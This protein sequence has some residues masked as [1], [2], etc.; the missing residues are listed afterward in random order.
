MQG[1]NFDHCPALVGVV[2]NKF[3][4]ATDFHN[5]RDDKDLHDVIK[6]T[7]FVRI[8]PKAYAGKKLRPLSPILHGNH[9]GMETFVERG[10]L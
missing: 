2:S 1:K 6:I 10:R 5:A 9:P 3:H 7:Y 8:K 4:G